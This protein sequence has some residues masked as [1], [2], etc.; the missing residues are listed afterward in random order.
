MEKWCDLKCKCRCP[1]VSHHLYHFLECNN[2]FMWQYFVCKAIPSAQPLTT[3][4][5][6]NEM[7]L[8]F[9]N[10]WCCVIFFPRIYMSRWSRALPFSNVSRR[11][12]ERQF[13]INK[14]W[15]E[16]QAIWLIVPS[17]AEFISRCDSEKILWV[18]ERRRRNVKLLQICN[19]KVAVISHNGFDSGGWLIIKID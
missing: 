10:N 6:S 16:P 7:K 1:T 3:S 17:S 13:F 5:L 9:F 12:P 14:Y 11:S 8:M 2:S 15:Q 18:N 4:S 19:V